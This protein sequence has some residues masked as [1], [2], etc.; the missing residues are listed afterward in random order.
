MIGRMTRAEFE[1][2]RNLPGKRIV[3][4]IEFLQSNQLRPNLTFEN[5][6]VENELA[7]DVVLNGTF[8]P[9]LPSVTYNFHV[10]S[11][12]GPVCRVCVNGAVHPGAG[13]THKHELRQE[14]DP[15][16]N[17]PAA[18]PAPIWRTRPPAR[19]GISSCKMQRSSTSA[20]L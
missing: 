10:N 15:S 11:A 5:V 19:F 13:R 16:R 14:R 9:D 6:K 4:K 2:L 18:V 7:M 12:G 3:A 1:L 17:L 8:K 20:S